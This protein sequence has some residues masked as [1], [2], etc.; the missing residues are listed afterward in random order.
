ML[1]EEQIKHNLGRGKDLRGEKFNRLT[2]L[3]PLEKRVK[4][5]IVWHCKCDCGNECDVIGSHIISGHTKS[6]GCMMIESSKKTGSKK[7]ID[8]TGQKFGKLTVIKRVDDYITPG[9][10]SHQVRYLCQCDCE[11]NTLVTV[12]SSNLKRG[13]VSSCGC[14]GKI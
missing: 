4:R 11:K 5:F 9:G 2:P 8:L 13:N 3:Y 14:M 7:F 6:C 12:L 1:T 10:N